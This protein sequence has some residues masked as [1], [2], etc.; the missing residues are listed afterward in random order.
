[1]SRPKISYHLCDISTRV[2]NATI[3]D[4]LTFNKVIKF[5]NSTPSHIT[6]PVMNLESLQLL[7][8]SDASFH[9]LPD[10]GKSGRIHSIFM[11]QILQ[12]RNYSL[13]LNKTQICD[14]IYPCCGG[15]S[16]R[17]MWYCILHWNLITDIPQI[18]TISVTALTNH[19]SLNNTI[20][21]D[22]LIL[23]HPLLVQV[24]PL[25]KMCGKNKISSDVLTK[26]GASTSFAKLSQYGTPI[27]VC[28]Y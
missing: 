12:F 22:K 13:K 15:F 10:G 18:Q 5:I 11:W 20:K 1:M 24:S 21:T 4:I 16:T 27:Y 25:Q 6:I 26:K 14:Q 23:H 9:N 8:H 2:K 7:L 3:T 28:K 19:H 17:L